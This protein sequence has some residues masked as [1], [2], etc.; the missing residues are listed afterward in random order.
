[1]ISEGDGKRI[2]IVDD[3]PS[4]R[5]F[6]QESLRLHGYDVSS[7]ESAEAVLNESAE[8]HY[9]LALL[10]IL[11]PGS[12]GLQLCKALR[13]HPGSAD[14][15]V[16]MMTA[17]YRQAD[18]ISAARE[19]Y[20]ATDYLFKP[21]PL[22]TL[23]E[24]IESLIGTPAARPGDGRLKVEGSLNET[25]FARIIHNLYSLRATGLLHLGNE[26]VR[27]VVYIRQGYPI[28][29]RSN[30]VR[31]F[32]GEL[33]LS[34]GLLDQEQLRESL[35]K[36]RES[37]RRHGTAL[38]EMG[39]L[40]PHQLQ[41]TL[42]SQVLEKLLDIFSWRDGSYRFV[43]AREFKAG[44]T[45]IDLSPAKLILQGLRDYAPREQVLK[46]IDPL[47][48]HYLTQA[49]NP[50]YRHQEI[51]ISGSDQ[52]ILNSIRGEVKLADLLKQHPL[53]RKAMEALFAALLCTGILNAQETRAPQT[54]ADAGRETEETRSRRESFLKDYAWMMEQDFFTLLGVNESDSRDQVRKSYYSLVKRYHPDRFFEDE[55]LLD[56]KDKVNVLF[57]RISDAHET[58]TDARARARYVNDLA[59]QPGPQA[60]TTLET[61]LEAETAFQKGLGFYRSRKYNDAEQAFAEALQRNP[62]EAEYVM[63]QAW[64]AYKAAPEKKELAGTQRQQLLHAVELNPK[65]SL[66]HLFLGYICKDEGDDKEARRRFERAIQC[67]PNCTEALRELRLMSMRQERSTKGKRGLFGKIFS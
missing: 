19:K 28:F 14:M 22:K 17:F 20:G 49:E 59:G 41:D 4:I 34:R 12:N 9:D 5:R 32:L 1:M 40:T 15:P 67:N 45:S 48:Q 56:L 62:N 60:S 39:L 36:A 44:I 31:E 43:Q 57:Q 11:L 50:L 8:R 35:A 7:Y 64:S 37:G 21:F 38:I 2:L 6:L 24:K 23:H 26:S 10:D 25:D 63:Y 61:I 18:H 29:V 30:L 13:T 66:A 16:I 54:I 52:H 55:T 42:Q 3:D 47:M 46:I 53:S 58:L 65:L 33:L 51:G 27:K